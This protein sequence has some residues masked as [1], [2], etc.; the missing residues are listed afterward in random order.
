MTRFYFPESNAG[1]SCW[2][3][4]FAGIF[5]GIVLTVFTNVAHG[6][7]SPDLAVEDFFALAELKLP[8]YF[9][10]GLDT[11]F[12]DDYFYRFYSLTE[13]YL[14]VSNDHVWLLGGEFGGDSVIDV[15][16]V[17]AIVAL[18][19]DLPDATSRLWNLTVS[20]TIYFEQTEGL[21]AGDLTFKNFDRLELQD[22]Q[23][24]DVNNAQE[25]I[26]EF[27]FYLEPHV[28]GIVL[29]FSAVFHDTSI[30]QTLG[31]T[32]EILTESGIF[33]YYLL[34]DYSR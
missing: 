9:P 28:P 17:T 19:N 18:L 5:L 8:D 15:G 2:R 4:V 33:K 23:L 32:F 21:G 22:V 14:G 30:R 12:L 3:Q 11:Q 29:L 6:Q 20:G 26:N 27:R 10:V 1:P 34:Y 24:L 31:V 16:E 7:Q 25:V 13:T